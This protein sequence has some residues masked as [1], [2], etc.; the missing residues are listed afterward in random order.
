MFSPGIGDQ[1]SWLIPSALVLLAVGLWLRRRMPRTDLRRAA[2]LAWGGWLV[3]T[4]LVFSFM[5][6]IF[7]QYYTV[8][9]VPAVGALVGMGAVELWSLRHE[10]L[11]RLVLAVAIGAATVWGFVLL[12]ATTAY[13]D[14]LRVAV[15]VVG[16]SAA[17]LVLGA[18]RL[19]GQ[20]ISLA[21]AAGLVAALAGPAAYTISTTQVG[22]TGSI[23]TAGPVAARAGGGPPGFRGFRAFAGGRA[24]GRAG[25]ATGG[26]LDAGAPSTPVVAG[27]SQDASRYTWVAATVGSQSAAGLQLASQ[28]PVMAVGG[29]NGSDPSP[30]LAQFQ[31]DVAAGRIHWFA[32][33]GRG[34]GGFRGFPGIGAFGRQMGGSDTA[35]QISGWVEQNFTPTQIDG[36]TF[37][38]LTQPLS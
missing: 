20:A 30:T 21:A 34:F 35:G 32:A 29:F 1:I 2:Y 3:V 26:L 27:L 36:T 19:R 38:D 14:W 6:G 7:H 16:G 13:G 25:G 28:L 31:Q 4:M 15:L 22:H 8:A 18:G 12:S 5:A 17:L 9:L 11:G 24:I 10:L 23:V 37:Y 33:S